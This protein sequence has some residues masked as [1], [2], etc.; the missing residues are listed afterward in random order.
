MSK[1]KYYSLERPFLSTA[2]RGGNSCCK[3]A[4][5]RSKAISNVY[6]VESA[7]SPI[8]PLNCAVRESKTMAWWHRHLWLAKPR[9]MCL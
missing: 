5:L 9:N 7:T 3:C 6:L 2:T 8:P 4:R 1:A